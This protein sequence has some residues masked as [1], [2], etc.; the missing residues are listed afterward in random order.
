MKKFGSETTIQG[1]NFTKAGKVR[2]QITF[3]RSKTLSVLKLFLNLFM[4]FIFT[5]LLL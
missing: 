4:H 2:D 5:V 1:Q 3:H